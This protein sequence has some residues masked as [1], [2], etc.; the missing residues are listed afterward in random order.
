VR[1]RPGYIRR[2]WVQ[3]EK[4]I[5]SHMTLWSFVQE[6]CPLTED[7]YMQARQLYFRYAVPTGGSAV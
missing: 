3:F 2:C 6:T 5:S 1:L 7:A 4:T